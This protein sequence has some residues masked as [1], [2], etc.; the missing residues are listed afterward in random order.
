[1]SRRRG[2]FEHRTSIFEGA[3]RAW[4]Y[5]GQLSPSELF[6]MHADEFNPLI[7]RDKEGVPLPTVDGRSS[8]GDDYVYEPLPRTGL[9]HPFVKAILRPWLGPDSDSEAMELGLTTLRTWWQHRRKGESG[10]AINALGTDRMRS[11]VDGYTRHF[12]TLAHVLIVQEQEQPPRSLQSKIRNLERSNPSSATSAIARRNNRGNAPSTSRTNSASL[13]SALMNNATTSNITPSNVDPYLNNS[14]AGLMRGLSTGSNA[15]SVHNGAGGF[16]HGSGAS[17]MITGGIGHGGG[18]NSVDLGY[19]IHQG[20]GRS[21]FTLGQMQG[22]DYGGSATS[23][24]YNTPMDS[25]INMHG[26]SYSSTG[27][28]GMNMYGGGDYLSTV[29]GQYGQYQR[30]HVGNSSYGLD[31]GTG[32]LGMQQSHNVGYS[33][34]EYGDEDPTAKRRRSDHSLSL[35]NGLTGNPMV[36][37]LASYSQA[38]QRAHRGADVSKILREQVA[39]ASSVDGTRQ[40]ESHTASNNS[41]SIKTTTSKSCCDSKDIYNDRPSSTA[42]IEVISR[43]PVVFVNKNQ[44]VQIGIEVEGINDLHCVKIIE[45]VLRGPQASNGSSTNGRAPIEGLIDAVADQN[46]NFVLIKIDKSSNAKR[47]AG[48]VIRNLSLV[49]YSAKVKEMAVTELFEAANSASRKQGP[50]GDLSMLFGAFEAVGSSKTE[51]GM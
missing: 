48:E 39:M 51:D 41:C 4:C 47:I 26:G 5:L 15:F 28:H 31:G 14:S 45:T 33:Y 10:T 30:Q 46:F 11:V 27:S 16:G 13:P 19:D 9:A 36:A 49:G 22:S 18:T 40:P 37:E 44:D 35:M 29:T 24:Y 34:S 8:A 32:S 21:S 20:R 6:A 42:N 12:F 25:S 17:D 50:G 38:S 7:A 43:M 23:L 1:M 2:E 3:F